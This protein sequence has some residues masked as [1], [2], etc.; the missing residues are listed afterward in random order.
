M[1][2]GERSLEADA[3][4]L[5]TLMSRYCALST[6]ATA[7]A[8]DGNDAVTTGDYTLDLSSG[9]GIPANV[10]AVDLLISAYWATA[11]TSA[12]LSLR[13]TTA[14]LNYIQIRGPSTATLVENGRVTCDASGDVALTV[15]GQTAN[16]V[17]VRILGF[18]L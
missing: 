5:Q 12:Q 13:P 16:N 3:A 6:A 18:Y 11:D 15:A 7:A 9:W 10:K 1:R 17:V 4:V 2:L 8:Y 14:V